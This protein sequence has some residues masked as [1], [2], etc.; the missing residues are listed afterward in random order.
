MEL[1]LKADGPEPQLTK[2]KSPVRITFLD[3]KR[4][5]PEKQFGYYLEPIGKKPLGDFSIN[6]LTDL[7]EYDKGIF[8]I[9]ERSYSSGLGNQG[10]T[11]KLFKV[12]ATKATNTLN[13]ISLKNKTFVSAI[14]T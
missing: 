9:I 6:G 13:M 10:N 7:L 5:K 14:K 11:I 4:K 1:P 3:A 8:F 12:D 2:T